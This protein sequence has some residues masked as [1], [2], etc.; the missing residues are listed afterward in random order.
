MMTHEDVSEL[1]ASYA[2]DAVVGDEVDEIELHL[3]ECPR[4]RADLDAY[5]DVAAA[6]G[7]SVEPL[8]DGLWESITAHLPERDDDERPPMP[9]LVF[10]EGMPSEPGT[11][12]RSRRGVLA[13]V[14]AFAVAAA[15][16][17]AVLG[18]GLVRADNKVDQEQ[19]ALG[20]GTPSALV[21]A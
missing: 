2:L 3:T 10:S 4:C 8:P 14:G 16:V 12:V 20:Q 6:M 11:G 9:H 13:V 1:L 21:T 19:V 18:I 7:N 15:A 17:A 5:R